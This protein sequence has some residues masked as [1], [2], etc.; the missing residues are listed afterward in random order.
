[1][2]WSSPQ[3]VHVAQGHQL[4]DVEKEEMNIYVRT[5]S[6]LFWKVTAKL[7]TTSYFYVGRFS[8]R[9]WAHYPSP[10]CHI[11]LWN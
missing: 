11:A 10:F 8:V 9:L 1:M 7:K 5:V 2:V 3:T 6:F 4:F